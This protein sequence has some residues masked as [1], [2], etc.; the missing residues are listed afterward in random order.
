ME[1]DK[2]KAEKIE[3]FVR[4]FGNAGAGCR[5][6]CECGRVF[7]NDDPSWDFEPGELEEL[8]ADPKASSM[9]HS[10]SSFYLEGKEFAVDCDC[11]H[12][13]A[14]QIM[15]FID[16]H[17]GQIAAYIN[18][19]AADALAAAKRMPTVGK[20][21][22]DWWKFLSELRENGLSPRGIKTLDKV[23]A[24][25]GGDIQGAVL[26]LKGMDRFDLLVIKNCGYS[27]VQEIRAF[28]KRQGARM[29][30][31]DVRFQS[32]DGKAIKE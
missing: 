22:R 13:R 4:A 15:A 25:V 17:N 20:E 14:L 31:Q 11:W 3:R 7:Y 23:G 18:A 27:T 32:N 30:D 8:R 19:C 5:R 21:E 9:I 26:T 1:N 24:L 29:I 16:G 12:E 10:V 28:M 2:G 6:E